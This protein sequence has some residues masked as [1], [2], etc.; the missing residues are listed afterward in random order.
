MNSLHKQVRAIASLEDF[1]DFAQ[2]LTEQYQ[3][4]PNEWGRNNNLEA[5]LEA[6]S[7]AAHSLPG[8]YAN[9]DEVFPRNPTWRTLAEILWLA[10]DCE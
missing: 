2:E 6:V 7:G 3:Q 5:F 1:A 9:Q 4:N 10:T 8:L